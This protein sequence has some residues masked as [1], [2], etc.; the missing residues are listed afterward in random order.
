MWYLPLA[1]LIIGVIFKERCFMGTA[2]KRLIA[3]NVL[4]LSIAGYHGIKKLTIFSPVFP[5][6]LA[7]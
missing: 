5:V 2:T 1:I 3:Y 6:E 7:F 4:L